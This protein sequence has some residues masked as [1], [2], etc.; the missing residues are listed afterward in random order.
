LLASLALTAQ[1]VRAAAIPVLSFQWEK[2]APDTVDG[3]RDYLGPTR[4][5]YI[6]PAAFLAQAGARIAYGSDWPVDPLDEWF[7][8]QVGVTRKN[9]PDI[10]SKYRGP[11]GTD[12]G[13]SRAAVLRAIT[14]GVSP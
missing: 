5:P 8:I 12:R 9:R 2:P 4:Y 14:D 7:A 6:E 1:G 10:D 13:L 3:A 11:L